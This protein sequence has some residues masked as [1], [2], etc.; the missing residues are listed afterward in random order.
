MD[1]F[2]RVP[3]TPSGIRDALGLL[4]SPIGG[5]YRKIGSNK[6]E[7]E[8]IGM[9]GVILFLMTDEEQ[10]CWHWSASAEVWQWR[11]G[12]PLVLVYDSIGTGRQHVGVGPNPSNG[13]AM[14]GT[15]PA[16]S[17]QKAGSLGAWSLVICITNPMLKFGGSRIAPVEWS[18]PSI[19]G[20]MT[21]EP[22]C[23]SIPRRLRVVDRA[24]T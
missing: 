20:P 18:P 8:Q 7:L 11:A 23:P 15:M 19:E 24:E 5:H 17:W 13:E 21:L 1:R 6:A 2:Y 14:Q 12:A 10:L 22:K 4:P 3:Q 9:G 16:Q